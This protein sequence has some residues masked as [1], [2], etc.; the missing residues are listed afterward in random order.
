MELEKKKKRE[1]KERIVHKREAKK[2][3][4]SPEVIAAQEEAKRKFKESWTTDACERASQK[5]HDLIKEE[6]IHSNHKGY[7]GKQPLACKGNQ[8]VAIAKLKAKRTKK[9]HG[10]PMPTFDLPIILPTSMVLE[11][12][13]YNKGIH[14]ISGALQIC[15]IG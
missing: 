9:T 5:L 4:N 2:L 10:T 1:A 8:E 11:S 13:S 15:L 12:I 6:G 14:L 7:L 3:A